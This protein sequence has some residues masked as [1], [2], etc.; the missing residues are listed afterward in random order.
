MVGVAFLSDREMTGI[1]EKYTGRRGAT[2][3]LS[4]PLGR[5]LRGGIWSGEILI[6]LDRAA[7]QAKEKGVTLTNEVIR[8]LVHAMVHLG[9]H[10]HYDPDGFLGMRRLEFELL[11][12][13]LK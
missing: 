8:L 12:R 7:R 10:D 3:V 11:L 6:S 13:C 5:D 1:N 9:G 4:F 2:D